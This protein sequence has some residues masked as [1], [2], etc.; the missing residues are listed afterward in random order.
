MPSLAVLYD[1]ESGQWQR[2]GKLVEEI[3]VHTLDKIIPTINYLDKRVEEEGLYAAGFVSYEAA[4]AFDE[5]LQTRNQD[6]F[7]LLRFG[8]FASLE[9]MQ[10]PAQ[11]QA[12]EPLT[13]QVQE[14]AG[15]FSAKIDKIR[16][17]IARGETYQVNLTFPLSAEFTGDPWQL[18]LQ[19]ARGQTAGGAGFLQSD[20]WAICSVS[21]ELFFARHG[22]QLTMRPMKGTMRRGRTA[23]EDDLQSKALEKSAK[24]RAE[25]IMILD[26]VRNDLGRLAPPGKVRTE[27][28]CSLEK[29]PTVWQLTSTA[30]ARS[31][32]PLV[33][34]FRALFPCASITGAPKVKTMEIISAIEEVP[35]RIYTGAFGWLKPGRQAH[36][37][38]AIRTVLVDRHHGR[39]SYGVGAGI[40]WDSDSAEEYHEC[41]DKAAVLSHPKL[42]FA[43]IETLRWTPGKGYF[44]LPE[45]L[46]RLQASAEYFNYPCSTE[47]ANIYLQALAE[48]FP[49]S[50]Q[51]VR[52]MLHSDGLLEGTFLPI[53]KAS[54]NPLKLSFARHAV[55]SRNI[56][57]FHKTT[58]REIYEKA[59]REAGDADEV[60]LWNERGE[61]TECC[62]ANLVIEKNGELITPA[63]SC[64]LLQGTYRR[65]LLR[66]GIIREEVIRRE[67]LRKSARIYLVSAVRK[68]RRA[69][70]LPD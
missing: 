41:L 52:L 57:L 55:D 68:W 37:N 67:E 66:R 23:E 59:L 46:A 14:S 16:A 24:N 29:Y 42:D 36:F 28:I 9:V 15:E 10:L 8:L 62:T 38:V 49:S 13:W 21:P 27:A 31:E 34:I 20:R 64:G 22:D 61:I 44:V 33:E 18:F 45:H 50:P 56:L 69:E 17:A 5:A 1:P 25:N 60:V 35:R 12:L 11:E 51:R 65:Y 48:G 47:Q 58:R 30:T 6:D 2:F 63:L 43:L 32:A 4:A 19:L 26:M 3:E 39:A 7:P 54:P 70:L 40:T 53:D